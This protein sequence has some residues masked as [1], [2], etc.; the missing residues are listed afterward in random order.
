MSIYGQ[1]IALTLDGKMLHSHCCIYTMRHS[2]S[3]THFIGFTLAM[4]LL[5]VTLSTVSPN[6]MD[7]LNV[8]VRFGTRPEAL[9]QYLPFM[10]VDGTLPYLHDDAVA[11]IED[12]TARQVEDAVHN[13]RQH[14]PDGARQLETAMQNMRQHLPDIAALA[15]ALRTKAEG[16]EDA[17][18]AASP[19]V[20]AAVQ[21]QQRV[22]SDYAAEVERR[23]GEMA[24]VAA[25]ATLSDASLTR[26]ASMRSALGDLA[27]VVSRPHLDVLAASQQ[28]LR[29]FSRQFGETSGAGF[30]SLAVLEAR[31]DEF[32]LRLTGLEDADTAPNSVG[33]HS[34][35]TRWPLAVFLLTAMACLGFS[36]FFHLFNAVSERTSNFLQCLDYAGIALLITGS[37]IP[38]IFYGFYCLEE[39]T[40]VA[41]ADGVSIPIIELADAAPSRPYL[42][43]YEQKQSPQLVQR[44][45]GKQRRVSVRKCVQL[46]F[47]DGRQLVCTADHKIRSAAGS[48]LKAGELRQ[49]SGEQI[50]TSVLAGV[51][52]PTA[53][54]GNADALLEQRF[55]LVLTFKDGTSLRKLSLSCVTTTQRR[56]AQAFSRL[57]GFALAAGRLQSAEIY[58]TLCHEMDVHSVER[59]V[60]TLMPGSKLTLSS[61]NTAMG[62]YC[63]RLPNTVACALRAA[64][65]EQVLPP[66]IAAS[67]CPLSLVRAFVAGVFGCG[68]FAPA[69]RD[70]ERFESLSLR[71][72]A[73]E[74]I[75]GVRIRAVHD[76]LVRLGLRGNQ[77][78]VDV[79]ACLIVIHASQWLVF[80]E[81]IGFAHSVDKQHRLSAGMCWARWR[82]GVLLQ[83]KGCLERM[84]GVSHQLLPE[85]R[86]LVAFELQRDVGV[87]CQDFSIPTVSDVQCGRLSFSQGPIGV[88]DFMSRHDAHHFSFATADA[89]GSIVDVL[90]EEFELSDLPSEGHFDSNKGSITL[91]PSY[92][93]PDFIE[94]N[95][96]SDELM[97]SC[98]NQSFSKTLQPISLELVHYR[99]VGQ[100]RVVDV[101]VPDTNALLAN[102]VIVHNCAPKLRQLYLVATTILGLIVFAITIM[103]SF[104]P[105]KYRTLKT[106]LFVSLGV[107]GAIPL[108]HLMLHFGTVHFIFWYLTAMGAF[109]LLGAAI[110]LSQIPERWSPGRF[111]I[112]GASHQ[113]WHLLIVVAVVT[114]YVGLI[115]FYEWRMHKLCPSADLQ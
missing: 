1:V 71:L 86:E 59:D 34:H 6:G 81:R 106:A 8:A 50:G 82:R 17:V 18:R 113:L 24:H 43:S 62:H 83:R 2:I 65:Q 9:R 48:W 87:L 55:Q 39:N 95:V 91:S 78:E 47:S 114:L 99:D 46:T 115:H 90:D 69:L 80:G 94:N 89:D 108:T 33:L 7:R 73:S 52:L 27:E 44:A 36:A 5:I 37:N 42:W 110:Y 51:Q 102:G 53:T 15:G 32:A 63:V 23:I 70:E 4:V 66:Y 75:N 96:S 84:E 112:I 26:L 98:S 10:R 19:D 49:R 12:P 11:D 35:L 31:L 45:C 92:G 100:R 105:L 60:Q 16:V 76:L 61:V 20:M 72:P 54:F 22:F 28:L 64:T 40:L 88:A 107:S 57:L 79:A 111:D 3:G 109:Y 41:S 77:S 14:L 104:R 56:H 29:D 101:H 38:V 97:I 68:G 58:L 13:M 103:P 74:A 25:N 67:D 21:R 30:E 93:Q 85:M